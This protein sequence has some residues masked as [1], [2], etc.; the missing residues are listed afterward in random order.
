MRKCFPIV[1]IAS[2]VFAQGPPS[3]V[4]IVAPANKMIAGQTLQLTA[5]SRDSSGVERPNDQFTWTVD[6]A[7]FAAVETS[8]GSVT[9]TSK[10]LGV[11]R[12]TARTGNITNSSLFQILP[13]RVVITP[14][15]ISVT[16]GGQM[17]F[18]A[19][20][21]DIN[22]R[23]L[24]GVTFSWSTTTTNLGTTNTSTIDRFGML[25]TVAVGNIYV[26]AIVGYNSVIA[27]FD[28][29][30]H[31][32]A[33]VS[34]RPPKSYSLKK[35]V[36]AGD[37]IPGPFELRGR[38]LAM[39]GNE[40]GQ[41]VFNSAL[42][43]LVNGP[44]MYT[45]GKWDLLAYGGL[46]GLLPQTMIAEFPTLAFNNKG[47][48]LSL[49]TVLFSGN[50]IYKF[51]LGQRTPLFVD[52][53]PLPGTEFL[54]GP[55]INRNCLNDSS[56]W[57]MRANYRVANAGPTFSGLFFV[58]NRGSAN[59][60]ASTMNQLPDFPY[61]FTLDADFGLS[62]TGLIY[63]TATSGARRALFVSDFSSITKVLEVGT[64]LLGSTVSRFLGNGFYMNNDG[65]LGV[66]VGLA[67][68][69]LHLLKYTGAK[70]TAPA[71]TLRLNSFSNLFGMSRGAGALFLGDGGRGY[72]LYLWDGTDAKLVF[73]QSNNQYTLRGK[74]VPQLDWAAVGGEGTVHFMVRSQDNIME[75]LRIRQG[76]TA[77]QVVVSSG[78]PVPINAA[79]VSV[80][81]VL[82]GD[83]MGPVHLLTGGR[84]SSIFQVQ[85]DGQL[86]RS[87]L[88]GERY[89][90]VQ[91]FTGANT[92]DTRK[93]SPGDLFVTPTNGAGVLR[94]KGSS[95]DLVIKP[96]LAL[97][98][99][100][101]INAPTYIAG[102]A[103]G[104]L[105]FNASTNRGDTRLVLIQGG[106]NVQLLT[107]SSVAAYI[108]QVD[109]QDVIGWSDQ[110]VDESGRVMATLRFRD[111]TTVLYLWQGG[112]WKK[113]ARVLE[114]Q[115][116]GATVNSISQIRTA[117]NSFYAIFN[118][119]GIG[120]VLARY[121]TDKWENVFDVNEVLATGN[122]MNSIGNYDV[123]RNGDI[124]AQCNT[125][126]QVLVVKR[127]AKTY[128][129]QMLTE[130]T[131][132]GDLL[133]R[134][135]D[136]DIRDDGTVYFLGM[137]VLD[138]YALYM[139]KPLN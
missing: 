31:A 39:L 139:A 129:I 35:L 114:S 96:G 64:P 73:L 78:D 127:G 20:A 137:N 49:T 120:N 9:L 62:G 123:N 71:K 135:S 138:E 83:R 92:G 46:A 97:P 60:I 1:L 75:L 115:L 89:S 130:L 131:P 16:V 34:I 53:Q 110:L 119:L 85:P 132:D 57:L 103:R 82:A 117:G 112:E 24:T 27:G 17:Q 54:T 67:N 50:V 79:Q 7:N 5:I 109:G 70:W 87:L 36:S 23:V 3:T 100:S 106:R 25:N 6:N 121:Q 66:V 69:Q 13:K 72:G 74:S 76:E 101:T 133:I 88:H 84:G 43:G 122:L 18:S 26:R 116:S 14:P 93:V 42:D 63:F 81:N 99:G 102:N 28:N 94:V 91:L 52:T 8:G 111:N 125:N 95:S 38:I 45:H 107:N 30:V 105:L 40:E 11:V 128:Y 48:V 134:T 2:G 29:Q 90:P 59:Q 80:Q 22:D 10:T 118:L 86:V 124:V 108:T 98:D 4:Q 104:D 47:E 56:D 126:T 51:A 58:P 136:F 32:I 113:V 61:P 37:L 44:L 65:D 33:N 55:S 19:A 15:N 68:G 12:V 77:A 21:I 41:I